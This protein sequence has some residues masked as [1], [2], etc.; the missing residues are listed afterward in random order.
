MPDIILKTT[1]NAPQKLVFNLARSID[2]HMLSLSHTNERAIAGRTAGL[3]ETDDTVTWRA[4]HLGITRE[5]TSHI[6]AVRP[7]D[8][9]A[10]VQVRGAFKSFR[11]EHHFKTLENGDT[12]MEDLFSYTSPLG[13]LGKLA[14]VL[15][16][17]KYMTRLLEQRNTALKI[18]AENGSWKTLPGMNNA[19]L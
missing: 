16:L 19:A 7:H 4:K 8:F 3:V 14:D 11:H 18:A 1:I 10:D 12:L 15:F 5:L 13:I 17:E 9:F 2:L 6:I